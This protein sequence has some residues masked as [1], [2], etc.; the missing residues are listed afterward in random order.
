MLFLIP[1]LW[2]GSGRTEEAIL[3]LGKYLFGDKSLETTLTEPKSDNVDNSSPRK[4]SVNALG[5][6]NLGNTLITL[7]D[8]LNKEYKTISFLREQLD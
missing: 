6:A 2:R 7:R 4:S 5:S 8:G 3:R 1:Q